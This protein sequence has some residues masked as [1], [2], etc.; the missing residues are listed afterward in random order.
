MYIPTYRKSSEV[1]RCLKGEGE[2]LPGLEER[3]HYRFNLGKK[4][5]Q[6]VVFPGE[7]LG[8][9]R[10]TTFRNLSRTEIMTVLP[11]PKNG[12]KPHRWAKT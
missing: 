11:R 2:A 7:Q 1:H 12:A 10:H 9:K 8:S 3:W 6:T 5:E 4:R